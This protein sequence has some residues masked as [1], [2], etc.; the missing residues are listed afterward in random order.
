MRQVTSDK[1]FIVNNY[2]LS[3]I[4]SLQIKI[5]SSGFLQNVA[6]CLRFFFT[7]F[8]HDCDMYSYFIRT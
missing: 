1:M 2:A 4:D 7:Y 8:C 3:L 5:S 6:A